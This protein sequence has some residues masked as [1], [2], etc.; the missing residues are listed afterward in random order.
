MPAAQRVGDP[1]DAGA[2]ITSTP[3][4][5]VFVN[6]IKVSV[7]G[8]PVQIHGHKNSHRPVTASGSPNVFV[9][10]IPVN[11]TGDSDTCGHSRVGGSKDVFVN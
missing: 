2:P 10:G 3:Q 7:N 11:R 6:N 8:S 4:D 1:N 9:N 5:T